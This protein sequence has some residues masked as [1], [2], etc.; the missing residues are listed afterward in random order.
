[1]KRH[2]DWSNPGRKGL[3]WLGHPLTDRDGRLQ[4][5][6]VVLSRKGN[7]VSGLGSASLGS[8]TLQQEGG[9]SVLG[10]EQ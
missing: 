3:I 5:V 9:I 6:G 2:Q 10:P 1:M 4:A 8:A 7:E